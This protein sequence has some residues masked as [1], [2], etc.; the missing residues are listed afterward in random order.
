M[1]WKTL[2]AVVQVL[3]PLVLLV[4]LPILFL[5]VLIDTAHDMLHALVIKLSRMDPRTRRGAPLR[6]R[7]KV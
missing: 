7:R 4:V 5:I 1:K 2:S 3:I 6:S